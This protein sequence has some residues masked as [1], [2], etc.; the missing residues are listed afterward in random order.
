MEVR[1]ETVKFGLDGYL[2]EIDLIDEEREE[3]RSE[4]AGVRRERRGCRGRT[5]NAASGARRGRAVG[6]VRR[7]RPGRSGKAL[8]KGMD[9]AP[10]VRL[11]RRSSRAYHK[12]RWFR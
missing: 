8:R 10:R 7:T 2:Y 6:G 5:I 11:G 3:V 4:L 9:V 1:H 12:D